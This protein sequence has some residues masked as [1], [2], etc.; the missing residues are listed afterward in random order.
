MGQNHSAALISANWDEREVERQLDR[1]Q[2]RHK[3]EG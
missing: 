2:A 1:D 3:L